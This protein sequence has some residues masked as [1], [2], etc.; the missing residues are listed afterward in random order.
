MWKKTKSRLAETATV[1]RRIAQREETLDK[2]FGVLEKREGEALKREQ[3][4][5]PA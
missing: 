1:E 3:R 2:K 4:V 5:D